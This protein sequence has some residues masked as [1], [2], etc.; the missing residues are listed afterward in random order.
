[1]KKL[2]VKFNFPF[3]SLSMILFEIGC[4]VQKWLQPIHAVLVA[5]KRQ[6]LHTLWHNLILNRHEQR[7]IPSA[8]RICHATVLTV[9]NSNVYMLRWHKC[10]YISRYWRW[11]C[12]YGYNKNILCILLKI[13]F[14]HFSFFRYFRLLKVRF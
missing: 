11:I 3:D 7:P 1:M 9:F 6:L 13:F 10:H 5:D 4:S 12:W 2:H 14:F 8:Q